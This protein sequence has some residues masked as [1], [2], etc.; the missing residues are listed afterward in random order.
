MFVL[1]LSHT[2]RHRHTLRNNL[3]RLPCVRYKTCTI[4]LSKLY[5]LYIPVDLS[6]KVVIC[7]YF[8]KEV[9]HHLPFGKKV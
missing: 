2:H 8:K 1:A 4:I 3:M 9:S 7:A 5:I 6:S